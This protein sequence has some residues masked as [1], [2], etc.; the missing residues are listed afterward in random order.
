MKQ[1]YVYILASGKNGTLYTGVT[2]NLIKRVHE[3]KS[4]VVPGFTKKYGA[5]KLV[6]F[7]IAISAESAIAR[8]KQL[9]SWNRQWKMELIELKNS[10]WEDLYEAL[11]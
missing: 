6:Y 3:H 2:S 5:D 4:K 11:L 8:E 10:D 7:E 9:K 1:Y